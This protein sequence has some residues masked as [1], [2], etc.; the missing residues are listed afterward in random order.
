MKCSNKTHGK[1]FKTLEIYAKIIEFSK[2]LSYSKI[3]EKSGNQSPN[4]LKYMKYLVVNQIVKIN[5]NIYFSDLYTLNYN[6][7][8]LNV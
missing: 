1:L 6:I 8:L 5:L 7:V 2:K 4:Q 3:I